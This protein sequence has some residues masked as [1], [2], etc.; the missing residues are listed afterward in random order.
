MKTGRTPHP[1]FL[2]TADG[3]AA[4]HGL[5][6]G[7]LPGFGH[8]RA[9]DGGAFEEFLGVEGVLGSR[10]HGGDEEPGP[11][12]CVAVEFDHGRNGEHGQGQ[13]LALFHAQVGRALA[14]LLHG[15]SDVGH[16]L[17]AA[18]DAG[19]ADACVHVFERHGL[20]A[21]LGGDLGRGFEAGQ[22]HGGVGGGVAGDDVADDG[23][24]VADLQRSDLAAGLGQG[25]R[26]FQDQL[27]L[28]R[29]GV[30]DARTDA[31]EP[32]LFGDVLEFR[33]LGEVHQH[34]AGVLAVLQFQH[35]VGAAGDDPGLPLLV[36]RTV[37]ASD[38]VAGKT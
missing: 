36:L 13:S 26:V 27:G 32:V 38:T 23:A 21:F 5:V 16:D 1:V 28:G 35:E 15:K 29:L 19:Q 8:G 7:Q 4:E 22:G 30:G 18:V 2:G 34:V 25:W 11:L 12:E 24:H 33:D 3:A 6:A 37:T 10:A 17:A 14:F 20:H 9:R 31:D